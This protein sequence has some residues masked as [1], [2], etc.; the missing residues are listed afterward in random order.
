MRH[1]PILLASALL[2][3]SCSGF[4]NIPP[5]ERRAFILTLDGGA[6][7]VLERMVA[8]GAM[9][10]LARIKARGAWMDYSVTNYPSKTAAGHAALWTGAYA[11]VNG[12]TSNK[13]FKLPLSAHAITEVEDGFDSRALLAE[14]LWVTAARAGKRVTVLQ[15]THTMPLS[16]YEPGGRFGGPFKGS[17]TILDGFGVAKGRDGVVRGGRGWRPA[18]G[19]TQAPAGREPMETR[20]PMGD[21]TWW[22]LAYDDPQDPVQGYD[23]VA[24]APQKAAAPVVLKPGAWTPGQRVDAP[25]GPSYVQFH[26]VALD[27][28]LDDWLLY[29]TPPTRVSTNKRELVETWFGAD[30][31]FM[32]QG[33][34]RL[35]A[36]GEFGPTLFK[37][38]DGGAERRYRAVVGRLTSLA[39]KRLTRLFAR[40]DWDLGFYYLPFPDEALHHW[41]GAVDP[42]GP[43]YDPQVAARVWEHLTEVCRQVDDVLAPLAA[44]EDTVVAVASDHG[45]S[46]THWSFHVNHALRAAG[47]LTLRPDGQVDLSRTR[48]LYPAT[49]GAFVAVNRRG[50]KGGIVA[51]A[52]VPKVLAQVEAA[53]RGVKTPEGKPVVT[54]MLRADTPEAK[55]LGIGGVRAGD[56][57]LDLAPGYYFDAKLDARGPFTRQDAG[58]AGHVYDPRRADMHAFMVLAGPGVKRGAAVG[59]ARNI[60]LAPT[61]SKLLGIPAPAQATG[62]PLTEALVGAE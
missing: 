21:R 6:E 23:T 51:A 62:R 47:L 4:A 25:T 61:I 22:A 54:A 56:L 49:D 11:D 34:G 31:P 20:V 3:T 9:P 35:W 57:Y 48:A 58:R 55:G 10:N 16:T 53:L 26:L 13:V 5:S 38:G 2:A 43:G 12:I 24:L 46:G 19:W 1:L 33:P 44:G 29:Y 39:R 36:Y 37:G 32:P 27:P 17:L 60:D 59:P 7:H 52:D 50:R 18:S 8:A 15:A 30:A 28:T 45:M 41:Y 14:P 42:A 40:R